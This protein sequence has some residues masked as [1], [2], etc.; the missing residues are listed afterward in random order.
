MP[1]PP[2][3]PDAGS[4]A[5]D[6]VALWELNSISHNDSFYTTDYQDKH[7]SVYSDGY[8]DLGVAAWLP[9]ARP[10]VVGPG[11]RPADPAAVHENLGYSGLTNVPM[12]FACDQ[13]ANTKPLY[14]LD[15][16]TP[17]RNHF[18]TTSPTEAE[19]AL[20][21]GWQFER[22][23]GYLFATQIDGSL[24]L[25]R[26]SRCWPAGS[27]CYV[28]HRYTLSAGAYG[29]LLEDG[30]SADGIEGYAFDGYD[31]PTVKVSAN[32]NVNGVAT[33]VSAPIQTSIQNVAPP[34]Q[35]I[36][37]SG[38]DSGRPAATVSGYVVSNSSPRPAGATR[39]RLI[40][41]LYTGTLFDPGT[42][43]DHIPVFIRFHAQMGVTCPGFS[44]HS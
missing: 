29:V 1:G 22:V 26:V 9:C 19:A 32:G 11:G 30:W 3:Q 21:S 38:V 25:Y 8:A 24:P 17:N 36:P 14:R 4:S 33:S 28:E 43:L 12:G 35:Y 41:A 39:Q 6:L 34:K 7:Q 27:G 37:I 42:N 2:P 16:N 15:Q 5:Y 31:N 13:P 20:S 18:Y 23:E 10:T 44:D 40:F